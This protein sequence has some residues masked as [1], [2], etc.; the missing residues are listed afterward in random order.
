MWE[1]GGLDPSKFIGMLSLL[2][3]ECWVVLVTSGY[4]LRGE[5]L[6]RRS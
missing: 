6:T 3:F 5:E 4:L 1:Q 2:E